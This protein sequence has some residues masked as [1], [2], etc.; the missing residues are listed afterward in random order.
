MPISPWSLW[1]ASADGTKTESIWYNFL[2]L[3][4]LTL[5]HTDGTLFTLIT[6][7]SLQE[8]VG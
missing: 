1:H 3:K 2:A 5:Y 8:K 7:Y 4:L 6:C